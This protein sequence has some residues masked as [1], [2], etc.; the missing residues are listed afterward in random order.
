MKRQFKIFAMS[1]A[2]LLVSV[3]AFG[4]QNLRTAYFLDGLRRIEGVTLVGTQTL[5]DRVGVIAVDY[6]NRDNAEAADD[7]E[8]NYGIL[9]RCG[10]H[11]APSAHKS[12]QT[13][14]RG[15]VRFSLGHTTTKEDI[16]A[17]LNAIAQM[18]K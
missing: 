6:V 13:F 17:A 8:Q 11:C 12:L 1:A 9:T 5:S 14:P 4:Q 16:D 2:A 10:L 18:A 15:V 7:L 3:A